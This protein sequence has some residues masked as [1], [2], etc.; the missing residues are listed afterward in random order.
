MNTERIGGMV[1]LRYKLLWAKTRSRNGRIALFFAGYLLFVMVLAL[2]VSGGFGAGILAARSGKAELVARIVLGSVFLQAMVAS[3]TLGFGMSNIFS[4]LELRRYPLRAHERFLVRH[5]IGIVDPFW[6]FFLLL[7][8]GL[9]AGLYIYG[10]TPFGQGVLAVLLLFLAN[11][12]IARVIGAG[13]DRL[14]QRRSGSVVLLAVFVSLSLLPSMAGPLFK[15]HPEWVPKLLEALGYTPPFGAAAAM[16]HT[17]TAALWGL[18]LVLVW[19][20]AALLVLVTMESRPPAVQREETLKVSWETPYERV[21]ALFPAAD[22]PFVAHWLRFYVRNNRFRA[23]Y[24]LALPLVAFLTFNM[25]RARSG[26]DALFVA[27]LGTFPMVTF[28]GTARFAVNQYGYTGGGFRRYLLLPG[29]PGA[30]L[31]AGAFASILLGAV[32]IPVAL[33]GWIALAPVAFDARM[34]LMLASSAITGLFVF[35]GLGL[36]VSMLN[37]KKGNYSSSFGNDLSLG[38]NIVLI[39]GVLVSIALPLALRQVA[40]AVVSPH[41]WW[42]GLGAA[43]AAVAFFVFSLRAAQGL[44]RQRR[45]RLLAVVEGRG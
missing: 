45:E 31:R 19:I 22:A 15:K 38:G 5:I 9:V 34:V 13:V 39:G 42:T 30:S 44:F 25:S 37:P 36:W 2:L 32:L 14:T 10:N 29:D 6:A 35:N 7:E 24:F 27:A 43:L 4:D 11:Y 1:G 21:A 23:M 41:N 18:A 12:L 16:S 26:D 8:L 28:L 33:L 3:V 20:L 17:G 40:P